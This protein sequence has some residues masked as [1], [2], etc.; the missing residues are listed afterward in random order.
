MKVFRYAVEAKLL[1]NK[2]HWKI[3]GVKKCSCFSIMCQQ[4]KDF[5]KSCQDL[6]EAH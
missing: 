3:T 4:S 5:S 1:A 6:C 2:P